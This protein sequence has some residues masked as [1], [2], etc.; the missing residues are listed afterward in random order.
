MHKKWSMFIFELIVLILF[1]L[2]V[3]SLQSNHLAH[4]INVLIFQVGPF[5]L[6]NCTILDSWYVVLCEMWWPTQKRL[7]CKDQGKLR[8]KSNSRVYSQ[9]RDQK[10]VDSQRGKLHRYRVKQKQSPVKG[11]GSKI[12]ESSMLEAIQKVKP[13]A[14]WGE[15]LQRSYIGK[16]G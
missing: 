16:T 12:L 1:C 7:R 9:S 15:N 8:V 13:G 2:F 11:H 3:L 6:Y 10:Q 5:E 14:S 4:W